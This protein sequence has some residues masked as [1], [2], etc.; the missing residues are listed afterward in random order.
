ME[1]EEIQT[2]LTLLEAGIPLSTSQR[3]AAIL[4]AWRLY[5]LGDQ[6]APT[7]QGAA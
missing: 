7:A 2:L 4:E 1:A 6:Q 3:I 5:Q